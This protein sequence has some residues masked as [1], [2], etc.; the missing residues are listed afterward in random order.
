MEVKAG[1]KLFVIDPRTYQADYDHAAANVALARAHLERVAAD[2]KRAEELMPR[3]AIS[4]SDF[5]LAKGDRDE[6]AA[7]VKVAE[8]ARDTAKQNLDWTIVTAPI[9]GRISRQMIDPGNLV[10]ADDTVLTTI[11][12][13]DPIYAYFDVD[14][15]TSLEFRRMLEAGKVQSARDVRVPVWLGLSDEEGYPHEGRIDFVDNALDPM[16]GTLQLRG[17]FANPKGLLA[18]GMLARVRVPVGTPHRAILVP[19]GALGSDQGKR[20]LYVVGKDNKVEYRPVTVGSLRDG[21]RV[22]EQGLS[23]KERVVVGGLQ[24]ISPNKVVRV[25]ES[26]TAGQEPAAAAAIRKPDAPLAGKADMAERS[27]KPQV[28]GKPAVPTL[29][30]H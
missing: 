9:S 10:K 14:E 8:A 20:F 5:D 7:S 17:K 13:Q 21:L 4:Q 25:K 1:D 29:S 30:A 2:F 18:P 28:S 6:G 24:A 23:E 22:I 12:S 11:V 16:T 26:K 19:E 15:R 3:K 27:A